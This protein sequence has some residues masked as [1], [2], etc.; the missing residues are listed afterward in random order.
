MNMNKP[1]FKEKE[2]A[3]SH[4]LS[5]GLEQPEGIVEFVKRMYQNLG[6]TYL[7][8]DLHQVISISVLVILGVIV[9][10]TVNMVN[11]TYST[12]FLLSPFSFVIVISLTEW[13]ERS[14]PLYELKMT[15]KYTLKDLIAFRTLCYSLIS[16]V[17]SVVLSVGVAGVLDSLRAMSIAFSALFLCT[18]FTVVITRRLNHHLSYLTA[19][20]VW[21]VINVL[22]LVIF[23]GSWEMFLSQIPF[24]LTL[25]ISVGLIYLYVKEL[26]QFINMNDREVGYD[27][28]G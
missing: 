6:L 5:E 18:L 25:A 1:T 15:F 19:F 17:I 26:K 24:G 8:Y 20:G 9:F 16:V 14:N 23:G 10:S 12:I 2:T 11:A 22:P 4:I 13:L 3:I 27:V 7:F 28:T 21:G